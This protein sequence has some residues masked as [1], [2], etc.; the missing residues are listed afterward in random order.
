M[1]DPC[2]TGRWWNYNSQ[3]H[4]NAAWE[5]ERLTL[6]W[7][8]SRPEL[9]KMLLASQEMSSKKRTEPSRWKRFTGK[10]TPKVIPIGSFEEYGLT[11][12]ATQS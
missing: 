1:S 11:L 10:L 12:G 4:P 2:L 5:E 7:I 8:K 6:L 9:E 3:H